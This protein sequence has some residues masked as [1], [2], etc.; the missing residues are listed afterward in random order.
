MDRNIIRYKMT[1]ITSEYNEY[2]K[3]KYEKIVAC[4]ITFL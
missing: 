1:I 3:M 4:L 2:Y